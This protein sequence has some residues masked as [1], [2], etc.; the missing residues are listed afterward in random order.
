VTEQTPEPVVELPP[1][2]RA[3]RP[4]RTGWRKA[5]RVLLISIGSVVAFVVLA[6]VAL[7]LWLH[8][9]TG[10]EELGRFVANEARTAIAGDIKVRDIRVGGF[11]HVCLDGAELR[12]PVGHKVLAAQSICVDISPLALRS[13][14]VQVNSVRLEKPWLE[15][16][17]VT[18][19]GAP[20][21][22]LAQALAPRHPQAEP[23]TPSGP[24]VWIIEARDVQLRGGEISIRPGVGEPATF[25]LQDLDV[26]GT[27]ATY[28]ESGTAAAL[29]LTAELAAPGRAPIALDLDAAIDGEVT[30]GKAS[31]TRLRVKLGESTLAIDGSWDLARQAGELRLRDLVLLPHDVRAVIPVQE[32]KAPQPAPLA[33]AVRGQA[34]LKSD[35]KTAQLSVKLQAG[36]GRIEAT[37]TGTLEKVPI[38]DLQ[39]AIDSVDP[40]GVSGL[41][42]RGE[43]TA[44]VALHGKGTPQLDEHGVRGEL[45]GNVHVGPARLEGVG[46][47]VTDL[48]ARIEG[49]TAL[50][51]AFSATA[52]GLSLKAHGSAA[53]DELSLD[54]EVNA[55]DL[56]HV[57]R[58]V[59]ALQRKRALPLSGSMHLAARLTGSL[60]AANAQVDLRAPKLRWDPTVVA[61][62]LVVQGVLRG[63][64]SE[65]DGS[66]RLSAQ[67]V[68]V[69]NIDLGAPRIDIGLEWPVAHLRIDAGVREGALAIAGDATIDDDKDGLLL[70]HFIA[71]WPGNQLHLT[72]DVNVH[73][74]DEVIVE[75]LELTGDHGSLRF[76][77]QLR[78]KTARQEASVE[79]ALVVSKF[80]LDRLPQFALPKDLG[81]H[82]VLDAN[83][84]IKGPK[85]EPDLDLRA[86]VQGAGAAPAGNLTLDAHTH[87]HVHEG[88]LRTD[89]WISSPR[90]LRLTFDGDLPATLL[91]SQPTAPLK[92]EAQLEQVDLAKLAEATKNLAAQKA[93]LHGLLQVHLTATGTLAQPRATL[94]TEVRDLG[95]NTVK[96]VDGTVGLLLEK[97]KLALDGTIGLHGLQ[98]L[99]LTAQAPFEL[100]RAMREPAYLRG[101]LE[102]PIKAEVAMMQL[103]LDR[104]AQAGLLPEGSSGKLSLSLRLA[105]T[106]LQPTLALNASGESVSVGRLHGLAFQAELGVADQVKLG[107]GAQAQ[108]DAVA[109]LDATARLSGGEIVELVQR[110]ADAEAIA[111]LLDRAV[112]LTLDIPGLPVARA[113]ELSGQKKVAEGRIVGH[114]SLAGTAAR[115]RLTGRLSVQDI[116]TN[117]RKLG[118]A[119]LYLEADSQGALF[120]LGIDPPGGGHFLGH[121]QLAADLGGRTLL[122]TGPASILEGKLKG[123]VQ[124][125]QLDLAFL[126]GLAPGVRR[127][128]GKLEGD[129]KIA[130]V[131]GAPQADGEGHLRGGL[132]DV[133]GQG[134]FEDVGLDA[135]FSPKEVVLDRLTGSTGT[136]TYSAVLVASRKPPTADGSDK[137]E[138]TGEVHLGD[139]ESVRDRKRPDGTPLPAGAV[140]IRQAGEQRMD[141]AG[142]LDLF[143]DYTD[144]LLTVNA[145]IPDAKV[146]IVALPD[147]KLP[148]LNPNPDV[149]L[150]HPGEKPHPPG[151]EPEEVVAEQKAIEEATFRMHAHLELNHLYVKAEDFEFPVESDIHFDYDARHPQDPIAEGTVH[152]PHGSFTALG[153]RFVIEDAKIV[154]TGGEI[155]DPELDIKARYENPKATVTIRVSGTAKNP[156]IDMTS[157]PPMDQDAI[158][159]FLATGRVQG[160]ATQQ[161]GGIDLSGAA[162]SVLGGILFGQLRKEMASVLPVD[163]LTIETGAQGVAMASVGKYIGDR[164]FIGYRQQFTPVQYQ[165][166]NEGRVEYEISKALTA[167]ATIGDKTRD[168]SVLWTKDF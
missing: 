1:P 20:T 30:T 9:G 88:R 28:S 38:W 163:V 13:H 132:F 68:S 142:E 71:A 81:L 90:L 108:G 145:K 39:L 23:T 5:G 99:A 67:R 8:T 164:I 14:H 158:A 77:A 168:I 121:A 41:A 105:G 78:P 17:S 10:A 22:T 131:L 128:G 3:P 112:A 75:P 126:S 92:L 139:D 115:P 85:D 35:G 18:V 107:A 52:L 162:T 62:G 45:R 137:I 69:S 86:D 141:I 89:G 16:A 60:E 31:V 12:D 50:I 151:K 34:D 61:D 33:G 153:R 79:V 166:T 150:V 53:R 149:L 136:G 118:A 116:A 95:T 165:N 24:F 25:A 80:E 146:Q 26:S 87:A 4:R 114:V 124:A 143:G 152:V 159:F 127:A 54:L 93:R 19:Q 117:S 55:P 49:R 2:A 48:E 144:S 104:V 74:G 66:L 160:Q 103:P 21:T 147:K 130:G 110:R 101:A 82:G 44:R 161:G 32:G 84:L 98:A 65:P 129:V 122:K 100:L 29:K 138:F 15:I 47:V 96:E 63:D 125:R 154:E 43:V 157:N 106:P 46:P 156:Q 70:S 113:S 133:V 42:P 11:V 36:G 111:P 7:L 40:G 56:A 83:A 73:F 155:D 91:A 140:P 119:D 134:V 109:R 102:R 51:K 97:G 6:V 27:R 64:L 59:G 72:H 120:H 135:K 76:S 58:A 167:E 37:A 94:A 123:G 57:G 148:S